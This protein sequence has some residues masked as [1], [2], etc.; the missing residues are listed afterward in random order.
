MAL[1]MLAAYYSLGC[2]SRELFQELKGYSSEI[3][4]VAINYDKDKIQKPHSCIIEKI[5]G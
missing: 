4:L 2:D 5:T 3:L 1:K